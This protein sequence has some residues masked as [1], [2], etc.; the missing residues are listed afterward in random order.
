MKVL[1]FLL[2][3]LFCIS[4]S[5][6]SSDAYAR[7][8][9]IRFPIED[10]LNGNAAVGKINSRIGLYFAGQDTPHVKKSFGGGRTNKKTNAS[11]KTDWRAC[12]WVFLSAIIQMQ[13]RAEQ[14]GA[15]AVINIRSNYKN[16]EFSSP[17]QFECGAGNIIAGVALKGEFVITE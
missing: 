9:R 1:S 13:A 3:A 17:T 6:I 8:S 14:L 15:N 11:N 7:D 4:V 16:R 10:A 12:E 5:L 2:T